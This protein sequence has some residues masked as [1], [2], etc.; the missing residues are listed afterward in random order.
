MQSA[1]EVID[2]L[3]RHRPAERVG[4]AENIWSDTLR[5]WVQQGYPT[6]EEGKPVDPTDHFGYDL[7]GAGGWFDCLPLRGYSEV[8]EETDEWRITRN[9]AGAA[10]KYWKDK[11]GT[12]EHIDF[13]MTSR[14]VWE[15]DYRP[16]LLTLDRERIDIEGAAE[17]LA[18][19]REKG[20]FATF[21][22]LFLWENMRQSMGD[23]CMYESLLLDP[24][25]IH[26]YNRVHTD[27]FIN[28]FRVLIEEAGVPDGVQLYEDLGYRNGLFCS[29]KTYE[30]LIFPYYREMV[31]FIHSYDIPALL[32]TCGRVTEALPL[33]VDAGFDYVDP[34]ERKA[35]CDPF[36][37]AER[38]GEKLVFRGGLD[39]RVLESG[40]RDRIR[41][42]VV[43]LVEGMKSRGARYIFSS[44]HSLSTN[45]RYAD[46]QY[47][48]E[49]YRD[50]MMY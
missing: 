12:P 16:H 39:V 17:G 32:H 25:W 47:A 6:T 40:D 11:S 50:H 29:P 38:Y 13:R 34:M 5:G 24:Q 10:L 18:R 45:V 20:I 4:L 19:R 35:G 49:V 1:K 44:D 9:G 2:N 31:D 41:K 27:F 46:Y 48:L 22:H 28:H 14:E 33:I 8:V 15:R 23:I 42:E 36:A 43:Q 3:L 7:T 30:E 26:D 21:G 37:F